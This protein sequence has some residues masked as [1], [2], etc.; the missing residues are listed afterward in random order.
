M[1]V[2]EPVAGNPVS[3]TLPVVTLHEGWVI[4]PGTGGVGSSGPA[5]MTTPAEG[6]EM[7]PDTLV[8]VKVYVPAGMLVIVVLVPV[9]VVVIP[10]GDRVTVHVPIEGNPLK[11]TLPPGELHDGWVI[12]P[13]TGGDGTTGGT[14]ITALGEAAEV[15]PEALVT[16]K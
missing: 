3:R 4:V 5:L 14:F 16:V 11:R 1:R 12:V 8:T 7:H 6:P 13:L 15:Q 9:P 2:H 10:P